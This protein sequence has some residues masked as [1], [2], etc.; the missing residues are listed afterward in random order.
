MSL[1]LQDLRAVNETLTAI[2]HEIGLRVAPAG[3]R[4]RPLLRAPGVEGVAAFEQHDAVD[5]ACDRCRDLVRDDRDH[6]LVEVVG[7]PGDVTRGD[8]CLTPTDPAEGNHIAVREDLADL[9]G[10]LEHRVGRSRISA[11]VVLQETLGHEQETANGAFVRALI[12]DGFRSAEPPARAG[13]VAAQQEVPAE[14]ERT[15]RRS[16]RIVGLDAEPVRLHPR[17]VALA[18]V[19]G[20]V[21]G[22]REPLQI[23]DLERVGVSGR[24]GR[25][26]VAPFAPFE[27]FARSGER[28]AGTWCA[29]PRRTHRGR[30]YDGAERV[31]TTDA[32]S[33]VFGGA[34][35][36]TLGA[37]TARS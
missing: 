3:E 26:G 16:H 19:A 14:P 36:L 27:T 18:V 7:S 23:V 37:R 24:Q 5:D 21:P 34:S 8:E 29:P 32:T 15:P 4:L 1:E 11:V 30:A 13:H 12:E 35:H 33:A 17:V 9:T 25:E 6:R 28:L 20:E 22:H 10:A 2:R 31:G